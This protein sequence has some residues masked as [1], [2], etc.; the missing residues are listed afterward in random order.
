[1]WS[2]GVGRLVLAALAVALPWAGLAAATPI[3]PAPPRERLAEARALQDRGAFAEADARYEALLA[4]L[5]PDAPPAERAPALLGESQIAA[6]RGEYER[7]ARTGRAAAQAYRA[8]RDASGEARGLKATGVAEL[9]QAE[10]PSALASFDAA[11]ALA[12]AAGD[13]E[14]EADLLNNVGTVHYLVARYLDALR[15]YRAAQ[16]VVDGAGAGPWQEGARRVTVSNVAALYQRLGAYDEALDLYRE[17]QRSPEAMTKSE[18]ARVLTNLGA[19]YRRLGDP[20]KALETYR[21]ARALFARE[22]HLGGELGVLKNAGIVQALDLGDLRAAREAFGAALALAD[23]SGQAREAMQ[24][25]LYRGE[26]A[27]RLGDLD[28]ARRDLEGALAAAGA[29]DTA[30]EEWKARY[31][32]GRLERRRGRD[33]LAAGHF[34][35]AIRAIEAVRAKLQLTALKTDFLADKRDVYDALVELAVEGGRTAEAF[36]LLERSRAR[37]FRDRLGGAEATTLAAVQARL[38]PGQLLLDYWFGP[39]SAAVVWATRDGAGLARLPLGADV[40]GAIG[41]FTQEV[42]SGGAGWRRGSAALG[43]ALLGPVAPLRQGDFAHLVVVPDGASSALPFELLEAPGDPPA[44]LLERADV[45][46]LPAAALLGRE[47]PRRRAFALPWER[48]LLGFGD[49]VVERGADELPGGARERLPASADEVHAVARLAGGRAELRLGR[50][51]VKEILVRGAARGVPLLHLATHAFADAANP[52]RSRILFS[53]R[54]T[55]GGVD[56]LFLRE[57][58]DLDLGGVDL[59]TLSACDTERGKVVR[60]EGLQAFSRALLSAGARATVTT[61]WRVEDGATAELMKQLYYELG[62][63]TPKAEALRRAKLR[64][65]RSGTALAH[66]R[67]WAAFVLNGDGA[68]PVPRAVP[69]RTL[70][71]PLALALAAL[72]FA[73]RSIAAR[74]ARRA[75]GTAAAT[76]GSRAARGARRRATASRP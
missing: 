26:T 10:Y 37:T 1:M 30:E 7:A 71:A 58:Y 8:A 19:L 43:A 4:D 72:A 63:G 55:D 23:G 28:G 27:L 76:P 65:L 52:E 47:A 53:P 20:L 5:G 17:L 25:R 12:R 66:P 44:L 45:T 60:G 22:R 40:E 48:H 33:D 14:T 67:T 61:L 50:D 35:A 24:A 69:W 15:A 38:G 39:A 49:P 54:A 75:A 9:Y 34:R 3:A 41:A 64:L 32:L 18:Q 70:L 57:V 74:R 73:A 11:I 16:R 13:R 51:D 36:E 21:A 59:A 6:S 62:R 68:R 46:Y 29:L 42:A 31:A 2:G 56:D